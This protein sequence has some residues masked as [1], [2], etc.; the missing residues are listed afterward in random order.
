M[1]LKAGCLSALVFMSV[2][3]IAAAGPIADAA[4]RAEALQAE[5]KTVEA[6]DSLNAAIDTVWTQAPLAF[7]KV[8]LVESSDGFGRYVERADRVFRPDEPMTIYVEPVA[9]GYGGSG[10]ATTV[11]LDVDLA[12][13]NSTGQVLTEAKN[14][15]EFSSEASPGRREL[16]LTLT[17]Q[18]PYL[19]PGD[20]RAIFNVRDRNSGKSGS[21]DL[22]FTLTLPASAGDPDAPDAPEATAPA[23]GGA[24]GA[25]DPAGM[26]GQSTDGA[27][28]TQ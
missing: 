27:A 13:E 28:A 15:V 23:A 7:R 10:P 11:D 2:S 25:A 17:L 12:I 4:M 20:Y 26:P 14:L 3:T 5:G 22:P 21:F 6:L 19:R 8:V 1:K 18:A 9:F 16:A 24:T